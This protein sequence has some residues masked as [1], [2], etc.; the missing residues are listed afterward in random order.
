M[1]HLLWSHV[2]NIAAVAYSSNIPQGEICDN[3]G[4]Y[5]VAKKLFTPFV[6]RLSGVS[7]VLLLGRFRGLVRGINMGGYGAEYMGYVMGAFKSSSLNMTPNS[8]QTVGLFFIRTCT[9][10]DSEFMERA[11]WGY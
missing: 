6:R 4:M 1:W 10:K 9:K 2:P 7:F 8:A 5:V 11:I 3:I